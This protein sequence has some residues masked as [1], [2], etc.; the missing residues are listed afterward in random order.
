LNEEEEGKYRIYDVY[1]RE[2]N[3]NYNGLIIIV[4]ERGK[5]SKFII[6]K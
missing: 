5:A 2:I 3:E 1:G 4:D 6:R